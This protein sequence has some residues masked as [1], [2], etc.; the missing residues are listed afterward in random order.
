MA[1]GRLFLLLAAA[2]PALAAPILD[3]LADPC[4]GTAQPKVNS[5]PVCYGG[6]MSILGDTW[7]ESVVLHIK[8]FDTATGKGFVSFDAEG[9]SPQHCGKTPFTKNPSSQDVTVDFGHCMSGATVDAKYCSDQVCV[10]PTAHCRQ[11]FA[12]VTHCPLSLLSSCLSRL[13]SGHGLDSRFRAEQ[14]RAQGAHHPQTRDVPKAPPWI[15]VIGP[16]TTHGAHTLLLRCCGVL[17][18]ACQESQREGRAHPTCARWQRLSGT[19]RRSAHA[20]ARLTAPRFMC[21]GSIFMSYMTMLYRVC[22]FSKL[23]FIVQWSV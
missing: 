7:S 23:H 20:D 10:L 12:R 14:A 6:K 3:I 2:V 13:G 18:F 11:L 4:T 8:E 22:C 21:L 16:S 17:A 9:A 15:G 5:L 1:H 19:Q